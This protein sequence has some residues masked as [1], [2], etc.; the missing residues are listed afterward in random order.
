MCADLQP[1]HFWALWGCNALLTAVFAIELCLKL[2]ALGPHDYVR[3]AC[4]ECRMSGRVTSL[5]V[6][7]RPH[8]WCSWSADCSAGGGVRGC[9]GGVYGLSRLPCPSCALTQAADSFN[10]FDGFIVIV[11][12]IDVAIGVAHAA[13]R[14][15]S[16][17]SF[18]I[19]V[20]RSLRILRLLRLLRAASTLAQITQVLSLSTAEYS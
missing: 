4:I 17:V 10:L 11:S 16:R 14:D 3:L 8:G 1:Y 6:T 2:F 12:S 20:L 19:S 18:S 9:T 7:W 5:L 15:S 13:E